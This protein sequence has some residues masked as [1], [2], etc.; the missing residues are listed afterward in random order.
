MSYFVKISSGKFLLI[1]IS[2]SYIILWKTEEVYMAGQM[3]GFKATELETEFLKQ[4]I[5][6]TNSNPTT[7]IKQLIQDAMEENK[8]LDEIEGIKKVIRESQGITKELVKQ[9]VKDVAALRFEVRCISIDRMGENK[10]KEIKETADEL[11]E[12][13][14]AN[15]IK[16]KVGEI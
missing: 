5:S 15:L 8:K 2:W 14:L 7:V 6:K 10:T 12:E 11:G 9:I 1:D 3:F 4:E 16:E 13:S